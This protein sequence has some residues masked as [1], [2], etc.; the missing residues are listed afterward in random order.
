[1][2]MCITRF[3]FSHHGVLMQVLAFVSAFG[4]TE[5][6]WLFQMQNVWRSFRN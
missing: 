2:K 3:A 6:D 1:M 4:C 5:Q